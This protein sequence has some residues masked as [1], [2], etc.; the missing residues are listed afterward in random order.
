MKAA[1]GIPL[2]LVSVEIT[3]AMMII[4]L[5]A[6]VRECKREMKGEGKVSLSSLLFDQRSSSDPLWVL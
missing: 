5:R 3:V 6:R 2:G 1:F 4:V